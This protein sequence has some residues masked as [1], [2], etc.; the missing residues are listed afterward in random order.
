MLP[1]PMIN[2]AIYYCKT[3]TVQCTKNN[4][5]IQI[6][7]LKNKS[8]LGFKAAYKMCNDVSIDYFGNAMTFSKQNVILEMITNCNRL[9]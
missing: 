3:L 5:K 7:V 6:C 9:K 4:Y 1:C 2:V 8:K